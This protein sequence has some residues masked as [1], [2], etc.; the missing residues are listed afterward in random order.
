MKKRTQTDRGAPCSP[1]I[2][3]S[4]E[5]KADLQRFRELA[6]RMGPKQKQAVILQMLVKPGTP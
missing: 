4:E 3:M 2:H 6:A 1:A 5:D